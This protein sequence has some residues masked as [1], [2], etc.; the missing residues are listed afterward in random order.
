MINILKFTMMIVISMAISMAQ[1]H[2]QEIIQCGLIILSKD[3]LF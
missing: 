3:N 2:D 1:S